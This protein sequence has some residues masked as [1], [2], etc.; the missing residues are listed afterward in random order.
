[1]LAENIQKE[2]ILKEIK[3]LSHRDLKKIVRMIHFMK[4]EILR[5]ER[6]KAHVR[7]MD[8]AGI[9]ADLSPEE[10]EHFTN[11]VQRKIMFGG[12]EF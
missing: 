5:E 8:Y 7:I 11:A 9:L 10:T 3:G 2:E 4:K 1:M 12:R 6:E